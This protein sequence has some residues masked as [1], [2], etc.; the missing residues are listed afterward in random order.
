ME[1]I[2]AHLDAGRCRPGALAGRIRANTP[3]KHERETVLR[4]IDKFTALF[5]AAASAQEQVIKVM[6]SS[7]PSA[8][9]YL[10][11]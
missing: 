3:E 10:K 4:M 5:E 8:T 2:G 7:E 11:T 1:G 6:A 9:S